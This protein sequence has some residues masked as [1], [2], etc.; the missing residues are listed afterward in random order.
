MSSAVPVG[1]ARVVSVNVVHAL[2]PL[3]T[4]RGGDSAIDKRPVVGRVHVGPLGLTGDTQANRDVHGG[5][6]KAVYAYASEDAAWWS[7]RIGRPVDPGLFGE[8][9]TTAG[10]DLSGAVIGE[11]WAVG[12]DGLRVRVAMPR[13]PCATF[14][15]RM[16]EA[17]WVRRF[18]EAARTGAYLSVTAVGSVG[19]GDRIRLVHRPDHEVRIVDVFTARDPVKVLRLLDWE[20]EGHHLAEPVRERLRLLASR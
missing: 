2:L 1:E 15:R 11:E 8:N 19:A 7:E 12:D 17:H 10:L 14:Q 3:A 13:S 16:G 4:P 20:A 6:D 9:L 5:P 18:T